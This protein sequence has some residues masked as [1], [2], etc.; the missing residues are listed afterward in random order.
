VSGDWIEI[1][2][3]RKIR[4]KFNLLFVNKEMIFHWW[5]DNVNNTP[6]LGLDK[7][8]NASLFHTWA[9]SGKRWSQLL[10]L[11]SAQLWFDCSICNNWLLS[12]VEHLYSSAPQQHYYGP[13]W[14]PKRVDRQPARLHCKADCRSCGVWL[15]PCKQANTT[16]LVSSIN[17]LR[18][19]HS[20]FVLLNQWAKFCLFWIS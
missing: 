18:A 3:Y 20:L 14:F 15:I 1:W 6:P 19:L 2:R 11:F 10:S 12:A 5:F 16:S 4:H 13:Q 7:I 8:A 17:Q 9:R